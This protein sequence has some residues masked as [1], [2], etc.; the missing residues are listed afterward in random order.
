LQR[1]AFLIEIKK[2]ITVHYI[3]VFVFSTLRKP[4]YYSCH[5]YFTT[6]SSYY[7]ITYYKDKIKVWWSIQIG[8]Y[9]HICQRYLLFLSNSKFQCPTENA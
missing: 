3:L 4:Y 2:K 9:S 6:A 1:E 5:G 7:I 8:I